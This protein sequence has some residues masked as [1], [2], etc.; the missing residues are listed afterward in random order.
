METSC[1]FIHLRQKGPK[2]ID[3]RGLDSLQEL[4]PDLFKDG[5]KFWRQPVA[6]LRRLNDLQPVVVPISDAGE[7]LG[8]L[9]TVNEPRNLP[10]VSS[11]RLR[12]FSSRS[13]AFLHAAK[14]HRRFLRGD[15]ELQEAAVKG[16][17][18]SYAR[19]KEQGYQVL[20]APFPDTE[21][22]PL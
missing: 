5:P 17:L 7:K 20:A 11:H 1:I 22:F 10:F 9:E 15:S 12:Q 4:P 19:P 16:C 13:F 3:I 21:V 18:Q 8:R 2:V 6:E 14:Q